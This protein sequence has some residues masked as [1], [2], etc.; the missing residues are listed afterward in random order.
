MLNTTDSARTYLPWPEDVA[1]GP[2]RYNPIYNPM[3]K[4]GAIA[5]I[6]A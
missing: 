6:P 4:R 3:P 2:P 5:T 1:E